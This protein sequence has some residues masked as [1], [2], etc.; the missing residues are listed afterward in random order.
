MK[1]TYLVSPM[2]LSLQMRLEQNKTICE[3]CG[4]EYT[5]LSDVQ[6]YCRRICYREAQKILTDKKWMK[7]LETD[8]SK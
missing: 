5:P 7:K 3:H 2:R 4:K 6:K 1:Q 8:I